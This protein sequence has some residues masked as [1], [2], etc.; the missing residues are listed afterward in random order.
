MV[1]ISANP[2][3]IW[4]PPPGFSTVW[5]VRFPEPPVFCWIFPKS[6]NYAAYPWA[7]SRLYCAVEN[8]FSPS[9]RSS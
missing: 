1:E 6:A 7:K 2:N 9:R 3:H 5:V 4:Q 8:E